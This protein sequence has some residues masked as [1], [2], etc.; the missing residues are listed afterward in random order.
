[1]VVDV[2]RAP[3]PASAAYAAGIAAGRWQDDPAQRA[4]LPELDR[5]RAAIL[6]AVPDTL[7]EKLSRLLRRRRAEIPGLYLW[8][9][10][11]RGK[12][13]LMD[14]LHDS[15]PPELTLRLHFHRF[16]GRV[17]ADLAA[18]GE[19]RDPLVEVARRFGERPLLCLDEFHV[20]DIGDA[21]ILGELLRQ[22]V[23]AGVTLVTT[24][25]TVPSQLYRDGLQRARFLP[26]IARLERH[27]RVVELASPRDWRL[28]TL[29]AAPVWHAP[30]DAA[31][32]AALADAYAALSHGREQDER[33]LVVNDRA[34]PLR[35]V[36]DAVAWF[37][38]DA[39]CLGP[40]AVADYIEIARTFNTV[41]LSGVPLFGGGD[42]DA[43][44]RF[45]H[46]VDEFY[47]RNVKLIA[48]AAAPIDA[49][50]RGERLREPFARTVS[51]LTEMGSREYLAR[52][53]RP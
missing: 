17:H 37:D 20:G 44:R 19:V 41:L 21:M 6:E 11:G 28:R 26:A 8:G 36:A 24:S 1:M 38:F 25:N 29:T 52:E 3:P 23:R 9:G 53:H 15:L 31:A 7:G 46:L 10:V 27:C 5:I 47:D 13:L 45:I 43:A 18:L 33:E 40:R 49:L 12:T 32:E 51:R 22:L 2:S 42:D 4:V 30:A 34:I 14:L 50:Y 16:M 39:L 48:S 35:R